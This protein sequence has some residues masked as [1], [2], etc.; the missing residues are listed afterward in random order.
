MTKRALILISLLF[1]GISVF[2]QSSKITIDVKGE[3]LNDVLVKLRDQYNFQFSYSDNLLSKYR[4]TAAKTF[5]KKEDAL[6]F[7]FKGLPFDIQKSGEVYVIV[8]IKV[9]EKEEKKVNL[10]QIAGQIVESGSYEPLPFSHV[11]VNNKPMVSDVMGGFNYIA[12]ADTTF[13]LRISHLGY[14]VYDTILSS[15]INRQFK[16]IPSSEKIPEVTVSN[17]I[18]EK[19]TLIGDK[20]G[21]IKLNHNISKYL[22]GQ[23]DNSLFSLIRLMPGI[24]AS[25]EQSTDLLIWGSSEGQSQVTFDEFTIFGLKNYNDNISIVNPFLVKNIEIYKGGYE[26]KYGNRVGG[27]VNITGKNGNMTKPALSLNINQTTLNGLLEIPSLLNSSIMIAYRQTYYDLYKNS[28]LNIYDISRPVSKSA[29]KY[30]NLNKLN[31]DVNAYPDNYSFRDFNVKFSANLDQNDN[32]YISFFGANDKFI[33]ASDTEI[34]KIGKGAK[35]NPFLFTIYNKEYNQQQGGSLFYGRTWANG[36]YSSLTLSHSYF[37]KDITETI[38][39]ES[40]YSGSFFKNERAGTGNTILENSLK[41]DNI[42]NFLNAHKIEAGGGVYFNEATISNTNKYSDNFDLD[43]LS[44]YN[45]YRAVVY[46]QDNI[47]LFNALDLKAGLRSNFIFNTRKFYFEPRISVSYNAKEYLKINASWGLYDQFIFKTINFDRDNNLSYLWLAAGKNIPVLKASHL[48]AGI[49]YFKND[50][51]INVEGYFKRTRDIVKRV[52]ESRTGLDMT[53]RDG[54]FPYNGMARSYGL[55]FFV[56]KDMGVH[57]FWISYNL[58]R[59]EEKI[60]LPGQ[61]NHEYVLAPHDQ[62]HELKAAAL[63]KIKSFY[64]S[65]NYVYGS[66]MKIIKDLF[67]DEVQS[68]YYSRFDAAVTYKFSFKKVNFETGL[69]IINVFNTQNLKIDNFKRINI[70]PEFGYITVYSEAVPFTPNL[71]LKIML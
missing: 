21:K 48:V 28:S 14:Y 40:K 11:W 49:N 41:I 33:L 55:E 70:S 43:T 2:S 51:T 26:A 31:F 19:A 56:K 34:T 32:F 20:P 22:P 3:Q 8:P 36:N 44:I 7:L 25:G 59:A 67:A 69:S 9:I 6:K 17:N 54:F 58:G 57:S 60:P 50:L 4:I 39:T 1:I 71:F 63:F 29:N 53:L 30:Q 61:N 10:A 12:S 13:H 52:F 65:A 64:I 38:E 42:F 46:V 18:I 62:R 5:K 23:G 45:N 24:A 27:L 66:G 35:N 47:H 37:D 16:L 68:I 15:G